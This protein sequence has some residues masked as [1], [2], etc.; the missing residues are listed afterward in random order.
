MAAIWLSTWLVVQEMLSLEGFGAPSGVVL[1]QQNGL[2][3][4]ELAT[5]CV[6]NLAAEVLV[7]EEV[8]E[9]QAHW[10]FQVLGEV[11]IFPVQQVLEIIYE[12]RILEEAALSED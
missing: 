4:D 8:E 11:W 1:P 7:L 2:V 3:I 10:I 12:R 6:Y 5:L 9:V